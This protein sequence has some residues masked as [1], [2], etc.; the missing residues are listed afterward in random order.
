MFV[1]GYD[2]ENFYVF[3][4]TRAPIEYL[5]YLENPH[6]MKI[7]KLEIKKRWGRFGRVWIVKPITKD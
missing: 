2:D 5:P 4:T 7:S 6:V 3:E 1:Y